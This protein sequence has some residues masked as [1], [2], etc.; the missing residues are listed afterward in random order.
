MGG[1]I[2]KYILIIFEIKFDYNVRYV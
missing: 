2:K 1:Q